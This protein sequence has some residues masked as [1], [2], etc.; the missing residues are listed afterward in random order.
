MPT[1]GTSISGEFNNTYVTPSPL[2]NTTY[3]VAIN[4]GTC[5]GIRSVLNTIVS[6]VPTA[7]ATI[8]S[9]SCGSG[10]VTLNASGGTNG[11]Y[12]W[13]IV[14]SGGTSISGEVNSTYTTPSISF[15]TAYF[16]RH[17]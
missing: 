12:R 3:Y 2:I 7:P 15:N 6:A 13:Y 8:G 5:E 14:A 9:S 17:Q 16:C 1:G 10:M 11:Q 4:N